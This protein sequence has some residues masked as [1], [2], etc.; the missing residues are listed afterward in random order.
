M[1]AGFTGSG[2]ANWPSAA[3]VVRR[4]ESRRQDYCPINRAT[5]KASTSYCSQ[6]REAAAGYRNSVQS[7][8]HCEAARL[9]V[10]SGRC[11]LADSPSPQSRTALR[12]TASGSGRQMR[13]PENGGRSGC[14]CCSATHEC[15]SASLL[16]PEYLPGSAN[17]I[18]VHERAV[19]FPDASIVP[20][21]SEYG[22]VPII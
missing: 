4:W 17:F 3:P 10:G 2:S 6:C 5:L 1:T 11:D 15:A 12:G 13:E 9:P 20:H 18:E 16:K 19:C 21:A 7:R 22:T 8:P 14:F